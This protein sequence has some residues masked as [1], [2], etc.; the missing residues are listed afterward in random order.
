[1]VRPA[2]IVGTADYPHPSFQS[3][4]TMSCMTRTPTQTGQTFAHGAIEP[5]DKCRV[6]LDASSRES[7]QFLRPLKRALGDASDHLDHV[8]L[9]RFFD[10]RANHDLWPR[11]QP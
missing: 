9:R 6:E 4:E 8:A 11:L 10:D 5:L 1:M 7:Q 3:G 2:E